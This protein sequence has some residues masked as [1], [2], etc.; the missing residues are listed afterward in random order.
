[1]PNVPK[2]AVLS[3]RLGADA[4]ERLEKRGRDSGGKSALGLRY[5]EEG[6][7]SDEHPG[8]VFRP[9]P[10]GRRPGLAAG[11]DVWEIIQTLKNVTARGHDAVGATATWLGL[12]TSQV[13][14]A[15]GYYADYRVDIDEWIERVQREAA[16][17]E[18][19]W[20]RRRQTLA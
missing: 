9:G 20:R 11:P 16:E 17:A 3:M 19:A 12:E 5:I 14:V 4:H 2:T 6:L 1:M 8:I 13:E 18:E 10:A 7:R 15:V